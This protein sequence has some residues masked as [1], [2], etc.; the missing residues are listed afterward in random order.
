MHGDVIE[1][2]ALSRRDSAVLRKRFPRDRNRF[3]LERKP[4]PSP[5]RA[6]QAPDRSGGHVCGFA[7]V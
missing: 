5:V 7:E 3:F 1:V 2:S 6:A 4:A